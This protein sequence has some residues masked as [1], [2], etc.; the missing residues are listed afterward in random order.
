MRGLRSPGHR[1]PAHV[2]RSAGNSCI[3]RRP[4]VVEVAPTASSPADAMSVAPVCFRISFARAI[5]SD[6]P[7]WADSRTPPS[8]SRPS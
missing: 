1:E 6:V 5:S 8:F 4:R 7:Q 3:E 2:C